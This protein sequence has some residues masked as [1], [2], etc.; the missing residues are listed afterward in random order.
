MPGRPETPPEPMVIDGPALSTQ[1][2]PLD[3]PASA[4]AGPAI[5]SER[6]A[7][8][9]MVT[10]SLFIRCDDL[11]RMGG[12]SGQGGRVG[13]VEAPRQPAGVDGPGLGSRTERTHRHRPRP[14]RHAVVPPVAAHVRAIDGD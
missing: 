9:E 11:S 7:T 3:A 6:Q 13:R 14:G 12:R 1:A 8:A 2:P 4:K 10:R 5:P